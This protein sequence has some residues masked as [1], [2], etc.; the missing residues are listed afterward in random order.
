[1]NEFK[2][3][4]FSRPELDNTCPNC[5]R[6]VTRCLRQPDCAAAT[7][8]QLRGMLSSTTAA[9]SVREQRIK[10]LE[11]LMSQWRDRAL[12]AERRLRENARTSWHTCL[13]CGTEYEEGWE[14]C[15][16][17]TTGD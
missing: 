17:A 5:R 13:R 10:E 11:G 8:D 9:L 3:D 7:V 4:P 12:F 15:P 16:H 6:P 1:M 2:V 14:T